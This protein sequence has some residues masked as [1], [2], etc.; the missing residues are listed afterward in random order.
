MEFTKG[1][2]V[3]HP[4]HGEMVVVLA[5]AGADPHYVLFTLQSP[6]EAQVVE[7]RDTDNLRP[8]GREI[9]LLIADSE[10]PKRDDAWRCTHP[11]PPTYIVLI[12]SGR[13]VKAGAIVDHACTVHQIPDT[14][15]IW[16]YDGPPLKRGDLWPDD[17]VTCLRECEY[18]DADYDEEFDRAWRAERAMEAGMAGGCRAYNEVMGHDI[19][20]E[21]W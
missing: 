3:E 15:G 20:R 8:I 21:E 9:S 13:G 5:L 16:L 1:Q 14:C 4:V 17:H 11:V 10:Y 19:E 6:E 7:V 18:S 12:A 2:L